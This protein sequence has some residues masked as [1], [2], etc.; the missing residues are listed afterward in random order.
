M[1]V[2]KLKAGALTI[3]TVNDEPIGLCRVVKNDYG[4]TDVYFPRGFKP[5]DGMRIRWFQPTDEDWDDF[6]AQYNDDHWE[7]TLCG[8]DGVREYMDAP[9]ECGEDCPSER[10]H[11]IPCRECDE[12]ERD[13]LIAMGRFLLARAAGVPTP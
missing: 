9:E 10:N 2:R 5:K 6:Y 8:G 1:E 4:S 13:K 3:L 11:L 7:C 12:I